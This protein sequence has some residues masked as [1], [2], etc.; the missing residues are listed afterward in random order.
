MRVHGYV[1]RTGTVDLNVTVNHTGVVNRK[2]E[3]QMQHDSYTMGYEFKLTSEKMII[4]LTYN[5]LLLRK[6]WFMHS[7]N[8]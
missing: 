4:T 8:V 2:C 6:R 7:V 3:R 5:E 1:N